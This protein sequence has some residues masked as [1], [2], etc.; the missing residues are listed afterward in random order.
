MIHGYKGIGQYLVF[1]VG[2]LELDNQAKITAATIAIAS[3]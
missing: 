3:E 1:R 2:G